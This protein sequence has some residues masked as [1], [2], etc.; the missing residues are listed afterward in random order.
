MER[1]ILEKSELK[2]NHWVC[3]DTIN[4]IVC[5]FENGKF[6]DTQVFTPLNDIKGIDVYKLPRIAGDMG[7]WLAENHHDKMF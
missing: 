1:Y 5:V 4:E 2:P 6:N 3:T 7:S